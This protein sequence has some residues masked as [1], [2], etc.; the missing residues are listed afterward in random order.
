[1]KAK[2]EAEI[3]RIEAELAAAKA[4]LADF[5]ENVPAELHHLEEEAWDR[6]KAFFARL[7]A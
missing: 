2:L 3:A 5:V 6:I 1:M 7:I 4:K